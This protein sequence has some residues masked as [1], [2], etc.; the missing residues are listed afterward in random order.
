MILGGVERIQVATA[1]K[2]VIKKIKGPQYAR[3][4]RIKIWV[5]IPLVYEEF[6]LTSSGDWIYTKVL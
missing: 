2:R 1:G 3:P 5:D 4:F 6:N